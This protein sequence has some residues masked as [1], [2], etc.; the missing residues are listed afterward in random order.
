MAS[1]YY[2]GPDGRVISF[3]AEVKADG[4]VRPR[5]YREFVEGKAIPETTKN[6]SQK[7]RSY[8][9]EAHISSQRSCTTASSVKKTK[10]QAPKTTTVTKPSKPVHKIKT[11]AGASRSQ[12]QFYLASVKSMIDCS[13]L[14]EPAKNY[15]LT[16]A[17]CL[18]TIPITKK[19]R[20]RIIWAGLENE[21]EEI[22]KIINR[23]NETIEDYF[24]LDSSVATNAKN[25][26]STSV[27]I[28]SRNASAKVLKKDLPP[29]QRGEYKSVKELNGQEFTQHVNNTV[30]VRKGRLPQFGYARDR[31]GRIQ[32]R[33]HY[34]ED[35][36]VN[37]YSSLSS[38]DAEDDH[39]SLDIL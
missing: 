2:I 28:A 25:V 34:V 23:I 35:R 11:L 38:Y 19:L 9:F 6:K 39:E 21:K 4:S 14:S 26:S 27:A 10:S 36:P 32:E 20:N 33:D 5:N 31:F 17:V 15:V 12:R 8:E 13:S 37:P 22:I 18:S 16:R 1:S 30:Y 24:G 7:K 3:D 29:S